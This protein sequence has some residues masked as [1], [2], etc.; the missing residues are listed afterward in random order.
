MKQ[1]F[2]MFFASLLALVLGSVLVVFLIVGIIASF[3]SSTN[4]EKETKVDA[5]SVLVIETDKQIH[6]TSEKNSFAIFN[7]SSG[8]TPGLYEIIQSLKQAKEDKNIK[9]IFIKVGMEPN[10]WATMNQMRTTLLDFKKSGKFIYAYGEVM[11]QKSF[12]ITSVADSIFLNPAGFAEFSGLSTQIP[13]FKGTLE[14]LEVEPVIFYAGKFKSA[15]EPFRADKMSEPN[16]Q[17]VTVLQNNIWQEM[18]AAVA[19]HSH[20]TPEQVHQI[21]MNGGIQFP[22]TAVQNKLVDGLRYF[23]EVE[24]LMRKKTDK[25]ET[26]KLNYVSI[27]DYA[28]NL[29]SSTNKEKDRIA[30]LMAEGEISDG[31]K[32]NDIEI[33]S[34]DMVDE[35]VKLR[36]N[37]NVKAVVLRVN[38]PG[39]SALASEVILRELQLLKKKKP[40]IVSMGDVAASGGYYISSCADSIFALPNTITGSIGVFTMMFNAEKMLHNKLGVTFDGVKNAPYADFP[41]LTRNMNAE[42]RNKMQMTVDT[43]YSMF[44]NRVVTGRKL[45][46]ILVDSIAQGRVWSGKDALNNGLIDAFGDLDR[47]IASAASKAKLTKYKVVTYP[48]TSD[49]LE[50]LMRKLGKNSVAKDVVKSA[51]AE[52]VSMGQ[53]KWL[54]ELMSLMKKN[55]RVQMAMPFS[56]DMK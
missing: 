14:K 55:G 21:A 50:V 32:N 48:Q 39:G 25:K 6:E 4:E 23:D 5:N 38:S 27:E 44:K 20:Q 3:A 43:I 18:I 8:Y 49:K 35:I 22:E 13:F 36:N 12:Y 33:A 17:Q 46:P 41:N 53:D 51:I 45:N 29:K 24:N 9:G 37:E 11:P 28:S 31:E 10:G 54:K 7:E 52:E 56:I 2:K 30:V 40:L 42:E 47:A 16:R 1:F 26:E 15:T 19:Q 34:K